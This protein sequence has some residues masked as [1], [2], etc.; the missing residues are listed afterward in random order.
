[1]AEMGALR[2]EIEALKGAVDPL[3]VSQPVILQRLDAIEERFTNFETAYHEDY[4]ELREKVA[5]VAGEF[6]QAMRTKTN[7]RPSTDPR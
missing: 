1:M 4:G 5:G 3:R 2:R 7:A 6:K